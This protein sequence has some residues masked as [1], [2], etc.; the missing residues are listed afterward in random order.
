METQDIHIYRDTVTGGLRAQ[1]VRRDMRHRFAGGDSKVP[2]R[3]FQI[4]QLQGSRVK[5][6]FRTTRAALGVSP[7]V[8]ESCDDNGAGRVHRRGR[9]C[10]IPVSST[11]PS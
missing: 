4:D 10:V 11:T 3:S 9:T 8:D 2:Y 6:I 7:G 5:R 1:D